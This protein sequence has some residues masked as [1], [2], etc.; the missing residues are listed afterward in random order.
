M[1]RTLSILLLS[2]CAISLMAQG[3]N[4]KCTIVNKDNDC[5]L[6]INLYEES[7]TIPGQE[8]LG[9]TYGY[10]KRNN[11]PRVW[12][13]TG[14]KIDKKDKKASLEIINDYGSEDLT[15]ELIKNDDGTYLFRQLEGSTIKLAVK[16]K[17]VK[18]PKSLI[19]SK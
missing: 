8:I 14:V 16:G 9:E 10:L 2:L 4:F 13:I 12:I 18:L 11:D 19:F 6:R 15:A 1:K 5:F 7:I 17:W 3:D